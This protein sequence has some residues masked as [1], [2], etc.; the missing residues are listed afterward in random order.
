MIE[1]IS[2]LGTTVYNAGNAALQAV[3]NNPGKTAAVILTAAGGAAAYYNDSAIATVA[4]GVTD[5]VTNYFSP[6]K[7]PV[8]MPHPPTAA[9]PGEFMIPVCIGGLALYNLNDE[10]MIPV[11]IGLALYDLA[12]YMHL[13][14]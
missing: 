9:F 14:G 2:T 4:K 1:P 8:P 7:P 13:K 5:Y 6:R 11:C 10:F 12:D 3:K